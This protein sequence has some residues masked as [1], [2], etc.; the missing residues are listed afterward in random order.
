MHFC[1]LLSLYVNFQPLW[2]PFQPHGFLYGFFPGRLDKLH[3][4]NLYRKVCGG[5]LCNLQRYEHFLERSLYLIIIQAQSG[6]SKLI[7]DGV[8]AVCAF[9]S[10]TVPYKAV[11]LQHLERHIVCNKLSV[12]SKLKTGQNL[13][14]YITIATLRA[15]PGAGDTQLCFQIQSTTRKCLSLNLCALMI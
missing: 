2:T 14:F 5:Q 9:R 3:G 15:F 1:F 4:Q 7:L 11:Y 13:S 8:W 10:G 12:P 6:K